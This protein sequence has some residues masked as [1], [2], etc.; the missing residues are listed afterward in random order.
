MLLPD[1]EWWDSVCT[2]LSCLAES[3][4][5]GWTDLLFTG[6]GEA[7]NVCFSFSSR[8]ES[9]AEMFYRSG[10]SLRQYLHM[11]GQIWVLAFALDSL[12]LERHGTLE[13]K[14]TL[15]CS[16]HSDTTFAGESSLPVHR[17][18]AVVSKHLE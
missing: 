4:L 6:D 12:W 10:N 5:N 15:P 16:T 18:W 9:S 17:S 14:E 1:W 11:P 2:F 8:C 3:K 13:K 7:F